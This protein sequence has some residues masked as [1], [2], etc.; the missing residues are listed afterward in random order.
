MGCSLTLRLDA[1]Q[2][3]SGIS[4]INYFRICLGLPIAD[5][6]EGTVGTED[7]GF[8]ANWYHSVGIC[9]SDYSA[10]HCNTCNFDYEFILS[11]TPHLS[12]WNSL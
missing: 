8:R 2:R 5:I 6:I 7:T 10:R 11:S 12:P 9:A 4:A 3:V 1:E